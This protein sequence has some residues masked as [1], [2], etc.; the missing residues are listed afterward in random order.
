LSCDQRTH[1]RPDI[2]AA[3]EED[4]MTRE[5][6][7]PAIL[8]IALALPLA[9]T[10]PALAW[11]D[12]GHMMIAASAYDQL[13]PRAK[14]RVAQLLTLNRY[15]TKGMNDASAA[16]AAKAAMMM[17]AT[18]PDAVRSDRTDFIDDGDD[19]TNHTKAPDP[20]RNS[21]FDDKFMH[22]YWHYI[23]EPF[24]PD[25]TARIDPPDINARQRI[26]LFRQT[27]ASNA[28]D[29]LKAYDLVWLLHLVGD[30]HQPLHATSRFTHD[31]P[32]GDR[33][34]N[35]VKLCVLPCKDELHAFWDDALGTG[36]KVSAAIAAARRL[37][38]PDPMDA[39]KSDEATWVQES[40]EAAQNVVY[41]APIGV[42]NGPFTIDE[43]YRNKARTEAEKRAALAAA[44]L[45]NL[46]NNEL[47]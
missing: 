4:I 16:D 27:I 6:T 39:K 12:H 29:D 3:N 24:S 2:S 35:E 26:G 45:A 17:A 38:S 32:K 31:G 43:P 15:P 14:A 25:H 5:I 36:D 42:G 40:F 8:S 9:L 7:M 13:S 23:D 28:G 18:A 47:K 21:G 41:T 10:R 44:R 20:G 22:K 1:S 34:G 11:D 46:L 33:G 37:P 19:P 30:V